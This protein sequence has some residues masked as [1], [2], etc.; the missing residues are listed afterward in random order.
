MS[1]VADKN[2]VFALLVGN[3]SHHATAWEWWENRE[4]TSV[5]L[6]LLVRLGVLRLL[7]DARAMEGSPVPPGDGIEAWDALKSDPRTFSLPLPEQ[8]HDI[9]FRRIVRGREPSPNL[10]TDA[11]LAALAVSLG[12]GLTSFDADFHSFQLAAFEHLKSQNT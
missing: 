10:W 12:I 4:D 7:T 9:A 1:T 3:H 6:C 5:G 8:A 11:W 2:V